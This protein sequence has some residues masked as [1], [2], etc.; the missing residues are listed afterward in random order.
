MLIL[1][2]MAPLARLGPLLALVFTAACA[3][4]VTATATDASTDTDAAVTQD[5][6]PRADVSPGCTLPNGAHC[7]TGASCPAGDGCNHCSCSASGLVACTELACVQACASDADCPAG[8][9]C[10]GA[11]GCGV[12]WRCAHLTCASVASTWCDCAGN[13]FTTPTA[14]AH[15][16]YAHVGVCE[17][18]TMPD[19]G[20]CA[21]AGAVC[22]TGD[23]CCD[24][25]CPIRGAVISACATPPA[26]TVPCNGALCNAATEYCELTYSDVPTPDSATCRPLP[27]SC[28]GTASCGCATNPCGGCAVRA[29]GVLTFRCPGG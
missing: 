1:P 14:C 22:Q 29:A 7:P 3:N 9:G 19:A 25:W 5:V 10:D 11:P 24:G 21:P 12:P 2:A 17:T 28:A 13:T 4:L 6:P 26:G 18:T 27:A 15:R 8:Q 16:P 23:D 20:T